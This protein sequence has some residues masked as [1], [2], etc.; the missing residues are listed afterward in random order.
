MY[1]PPHPE[2]SGENENAPSMYSIYPFLQEY[3]V[4][5]ELMSEDKGE[6][7]EK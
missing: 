7:E 5:M 3:S 1:K 4:V 6:T 2:L